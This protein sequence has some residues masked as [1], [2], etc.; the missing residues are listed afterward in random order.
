[1]EGHLGIAEEL[2]ER[3]P[4]TPQ[5]VGDAIPTFWVAPEQAPELLRY[6]KEDVPESYGTL[7]DLSAID[8]RSHVSRQAQP[9]SDFTVV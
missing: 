1:M 8:E 7:Y 3:Y 4:V 2:Q 9:E 6:L 5:P